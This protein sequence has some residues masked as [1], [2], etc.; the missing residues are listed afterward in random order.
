MD[1]T[2]EKHAIT[3]LP[4][5]DRARQVEG[6]LVEFVERADL[7]PGS[8]LPAERELMSAL[9][10]GRSTIREVIRK[11]QALGIIDSR[12]GSGNY[13]LKPIS[14]ATVH[15]PISIEAQSL[16][17]ALLMTLEVRRGIEVE[18]SMAAARR[19]TEDDI[20]TMRLRL[21]E[22]ERVHL[23]EGTSGKADLAFHL[24]IY[25]ATHNSLFKQ[26]LE[27][28]REGFERF[29]S[30]PFDR[31][32]FASRSFPFH[33]TLFNAIVAGDTSAA[34]QETLKILAIVEEDIKDMS[35]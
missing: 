31:P 15:M 16:R 13:L 17:D 32:D 5:I 1:Q 8:R 22:M 27:Q 30:K 18:A 33:R 10:V 12:K 11:F 3:P 9:G 2:L 23:A 6:A 26:L 34:R 24:S 29:W 19:R 35:K 14:T 28:M 4:V 20:K 25:D 7:K 21:E